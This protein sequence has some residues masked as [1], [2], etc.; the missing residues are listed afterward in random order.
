MYYHDDSD[1]PDSELEAPDELVEAL[2]G[3]AQGIRVP[4]SPETDQKILA[5]A[6]E[7]CEPAQP[8]TKSLMIR[9]WIG[10]AAA[11]TALLAIGYLVMNETNQPKK[12]TVVLVSSELAISVEDTANVTLNQNMSTS[13]E[14][15]IFHAHGDV[16]IIASNSAS[17]QAP[18]PHEDYYSL[19]NDGVGDNHGSP[20]KRKLVTIEG[21]IF[22]L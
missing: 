8:V 14:I 2:R 12:G 20:S 7:R 6:R 5:M 16:P 19:E 21:D 22:S 15:T 4:V 11:L 17:I 1:I 13:E 9:P 18:E 10:L 3:Y